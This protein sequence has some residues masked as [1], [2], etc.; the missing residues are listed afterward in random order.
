ME[1]KPYSLKRG[2]LKTPYPSFCYFPSLLPTYLPDVYLYAAPACQST[3]TV[4]LIFYFCFLTPHCFFHN[5]LIYCTTIAERREV[6]WLWDW[7]NFKKEKSVGQGN[8]KVDRSLNFKAVFS[9][10]W[11]FMNRNFFFFNSL[12]KK[13]SSLLTKSRNFYSWI[14]EVTGYFLNFPDFFTI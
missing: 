12:K 6:Y 13:V 7:R 1:S 9:V 2:N 3:S 11:N 5:K 4:F 10:L 8:K 14:S